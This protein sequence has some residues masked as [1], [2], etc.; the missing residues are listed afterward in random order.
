MRFPDLPAVWGNLRYQRVRRRLAA[1]KLLRAFADAY[2]RARFVEIGS[3]DGRK[4]DQLRPFILR[5]EW[6]GIMVEPVPH[7]FER[8]RENYGGIDR[9]ALE[10][11]AI[12]DHDGTVEFF[13]P[14]APA[15][16][17][18]RRLPEWYDGI[19]SL[20]REAV[21]SHAPQIPDLEARLRTAEL[22]CVTFATLLERNGLDRVD[23][24]LVDT[25]G[26]DA[27]IVRGLGLAERRPRL[28]V[29]EHFHLGP[30]E[31]AE[32]AAYVRA[33]GYE[34]MEEGFDTYCLDAGPDD[35]LTR[36]WRGLR[37]FIPGVSTHDPP[38]PG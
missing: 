36:T 20:S 21:L 2:P 33:Q 1:P 19:G 11:V 28:L 22:P 27:R 29:Y 12:A 7:I 31:R 26:S 24:V 6:R 32:C 30:E 5:R 37:P 35:A 10:N 15:E 34:T 4:H 8:L 3:N 9:L 14:A 16:G 25:E 13:Y 38:P 18:A 23:L 17:E